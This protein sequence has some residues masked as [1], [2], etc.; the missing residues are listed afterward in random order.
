[1]HRLAI[2]VRLVALFALAFLLTAPLARAD[3]AFDRFLTSQAWPVARGMGVKRSTFDRELRGVTPDRSL[4]GLGN[5]KSGPNFQAEFKSPSR[6]FRGASQLAGTGRKLASRHA[7]TLAEIERRTG[8]PGRIVLAIWARESAYGNA[9]IPHDAIRVL[10]T[11][12]WLDGR[13]EFYARELAAALLMLQRGDIS[14][15]AM[16]SSWAGAMGQPQFMPTSYLEHA[17]DGDGDGRADIWRSVPDTLMS[18]GNYLKDFGWQRGRDWGYEAAIPASLSC[19]MEGP[20]GLRP[21]ADWARAGV[22]RASGSPLPGKEMRKRGSL[23]MPAGR[24][25]PAFIA[26]PN[27]YAIKKYNNSDLYAL[28][29]GHL[30]D[31]IAFGAGDFRGRWGG[32]SGGASGLTRGQVRDMQRTLIAQGHDVG[33][34]DGLAGYKTRRSI[35]R[36]QEANGVRPTCWPSRAL[37]GRIG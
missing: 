3:P 30:A 16:R 36:W 27:F 12:A 11:R 31:R 29:V 18:I 4:P 37:A 17:A 26:T 24:E 8:V 14:R 5:A 6:Y 21:F 28:F 1:M 34:A 10:A 32:G 9:K 25:G 35:G 13:T 22:T 15:Q 23:L 20:D 7:R 33:G 2:L 19:S